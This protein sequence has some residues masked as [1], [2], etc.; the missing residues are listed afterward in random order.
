MP[1]LLLCARFPTWAL[2]NRW[3][4]LEDLDLGLFS[5]L[6]SPASLYTWTR[7]SGT[8]TRADP[9]VVQW[10]AKGWVRKGGTSSQGLPPPTMWGEVFS[11][12]M[13]LGDV[14]KPLEPVLPFSSG[15][16][17]SERGLTLALK[18]NNPTH[19]LLL[20]IIRCHILYTI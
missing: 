15:I 5:A 18:Q 1:C 9:T 14:V 13:I 12:F 8:P 16:R 11:G 4:T 17:C 7:T 2:P 3:L 20:S 10:G 6:V 19:L